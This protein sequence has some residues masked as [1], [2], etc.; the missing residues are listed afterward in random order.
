ML[1]SLERDVFSDGFGSGHVLQSLKTIRGCNLK[2]LEVS[3]WH[4]WPVVVVVF[5]V[6]DR[7]RWV[8]DLGWGAVCSYRCWGTWLLKDDLCNARC[9]VHM[10][11]WVCMERHTHSFLRVKPLEF[12]LGRRIL[13]NINVVLNSRW[14]ILWFVHFLE[15]ILLSIWLY[16]WHMVWTKWSWFLQILTHILDL[17]FYLLYLL[18]YVVRWRRAK[19]M[20]VDR[21]S[22][23]TV[24]ARLWNYTRHLKRHVSLWNVGKTFVHCWNRLVIFD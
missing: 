24:F 13:M 23:C 4:D 17:Y 1:L 14:K 6:H 22:F 2:D 19:L 8:W 10:L 5:G 7:G 3:S 12:L 18:W 9:R 21:W 20:P 15:F 11:R 16:R